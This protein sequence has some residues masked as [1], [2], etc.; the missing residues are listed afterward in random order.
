M[1]A[2]PQAGVM[3]S[4]LTNPPREGRAFGRRTV[5]ASVAALPF[6]SLSGTPAQFTDFIRLEIA[7]Y[8]QVIQ[9]AHISV[10]G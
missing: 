6:G 1:N 3:G 10:K 2:A 4:S 5:V 8:A 9:R 7:R